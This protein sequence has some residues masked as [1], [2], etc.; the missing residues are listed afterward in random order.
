[1]SDMP[2]ADNL[3]QLSKQR[4]REL[5][6]RDFISYL[7]QTDLSNSRRYFELARYTT[8]Q[9]DKV[10]LMAGAVV[11]I[12]AAILVGAT[13][14]FFTLLSGLAAFGATLIVIF[15]IHWIR[16]PGAF[17]KVVLAKATAAK[18][19]LEQEKA[20]NAEAKLAG[21]IDC[22]DH[23]TAWDLERFGVDR[24]TPLK[25]KVTFTLNVCLWNESSVATTVSGFS[26]WL[27]WRDGQYQ[28]HEL[29]IDGYSVQRTFPRPEP[30]E[31]GY[32][33]RSE[34]LVEFPT[35]LEITNRNHTNGWLRFLARDIPSEAEGDAALSHELTWKL[36]AH[37]RKG[38]PHKIYEGTWDLPPCG[39]VK[40]D[41]D[42]LF[43]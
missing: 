30:Q 12:F 35:N 38:Q 2:T 11:G 20:T 16:S 21:R 34:P 6:K 23:E 25:L 37:D 18:L 17:Y 31:W 43:A 19:L 24:A 36:Y 5:E 1:M 22:L 41:N 3:V 27:L 13:T 40:R 29:P 4:A 32:E 28:A 33:V 15:V 9:H 26:L 7:L 8:R 14:W 39:D 42:F 10:E